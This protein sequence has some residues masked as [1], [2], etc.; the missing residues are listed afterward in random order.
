[1]LR[2][3]FS[4]LLLFSVKVYCLPFYNSFTSLDYITRYRE[5]ALKEMKCYNIPASIILAQAM[6]ESG[7][8][9]SNLAT[10]ANNHF[11]IKCHKEWHGPTFIMDDDENDECFRKYESVVDSYS[12]HSLFLC[13]RRWYAFLFQLPKTDYVAWARGLKSAGYATHPAYAEMLIEVI[14]KNRLYE[15]DTMTAESITPLLAAEKKEESHGMTL[16]TR[17]LLSLLNDLDL[18]K[19]KDEPLTSTE[20]DSLYSVY[21][22]SSRITTD[23]G[24]NSGFNAENNFEPEIVAVAE[25]N[26]ENKVAIVTENKIAEKTK[27]KT[28]LNF[29]HYASTVTNIYEIAYGYGNNYVGEL[30]TESVVFSCKNIT[31]QKTSISLNYTTTLQDTDCRIETPKVIEP[32]QSAPGFKESY[33]F[34]QE[35][36]MNAFIYSVQGFL[37]E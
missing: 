5:L 12:D 9:S 32:L 23:E 19:L 22:N 13:S 36:N 3:L 28:T 11:G 21:F 4:I 7:N 24:E 6:V 27:R 15:L 14:E 35:N 2:R 18:D 31:I 1:M 37:I 30:N 17:E 16:A 26:F 25:N 10:N 29:E 8:G 33:F 20:T 34:Q